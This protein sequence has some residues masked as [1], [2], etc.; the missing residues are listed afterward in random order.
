MHL[1]LDPRGYV[2]H[3]YLK[4]CEPRQSL[5][6]KSDDLAWYLEESKCNPK[7]SPAYWD[8]RHTP[9]MT[10]HCWWT[11]H[12]GILMMAHYPWAVES[13]MYSKKTF[14]K[15]MVFWLVVSTHLKNISQIGNLPQIGMKIKNLWNHH[16]VLVTALQWYHQH[17]H[18]SQ[19]LVARGSS[20]L[21]VTVP[22]ASLDPRGCPDIA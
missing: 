7:R 12:D 20:S 22:A 15:N 19:C 17:T 14:K 21:S 2:I 11:V 18:M 10:F 3:P 4:E 9:N 1:D 6:V 16:L 5:P 13:P 8:E